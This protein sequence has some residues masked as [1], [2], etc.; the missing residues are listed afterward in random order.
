MNAGRRTLAT[1]RVSRSIENRAPAEILKKYPRERGETDSQGLR[2]N[3]CSPLTYCREKQG[4]RGD[5]EK[6][7]VGK[8]RNR[9]E[10]R[11]VKTCN[12]PR[13]L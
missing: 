12:L 1:F 3:T 6:I 10:R 8:R 7:S 11:K 9:F 5:F 4:S 2:A 13:S